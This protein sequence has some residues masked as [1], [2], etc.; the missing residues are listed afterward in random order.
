MQNE[1]QRNR[2]HH[3]NHRG[4]EASGVNAMLR[5]CTRATAIPQRQRHHR[6]RKAGKTATSRVV[7]IA[8]RTTIQ[9]LTNSCKHTCVGLLAA[10]QPIQCKYNNTACDK[11]AKIAASAWWH[12]GAL[13]L[14]L[15]EGAGGPA[16]LNKWP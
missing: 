10:E 6:Q 13:R 1:S 11:S 12:A 5:E 3:P 16:Y 4:E 15:G 7:A 8:I 14:E 2:T 9:L